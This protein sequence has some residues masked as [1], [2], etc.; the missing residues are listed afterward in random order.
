MSSSLKTLKKMN[1][2]PKTRKIK[3]FEKI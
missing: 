3:N 1:K 2:C